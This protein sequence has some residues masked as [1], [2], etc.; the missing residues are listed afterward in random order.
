MKKAQA[1]VEFMLF[2]LAAIAFITI[3]IGSM[4]LAQKRAI[5]QGEAI[6]KTIALEGLARTIE[7]HA[8]IGLIM[9]IDMDSSGYRINGNRLEAD[10]GN[11]TIVV[12][13]IF[14][15]KGARYEP[16]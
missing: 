4:G 1:T 9:I 2:F 11:K 12:E 5:A 8:N 13:G 3:L 15:N 10:Y 16:I 6:E 14:E 7:T